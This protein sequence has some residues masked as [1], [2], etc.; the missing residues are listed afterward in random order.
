MKQ[1]HLHKIALLVAMLLI[2][3]ISWAD[4]LNVGDEFTENGI[5]YKVTNTSPLEAQVVSVDTSTEG[6]VTIVKRV[7]GSDGKYYSVTEIGGNA[8]RDCVQVTEVSIP[9]TVRSIGG[10]AFK[11]CKGLTS[12]LIPNSVTEIANEAFFNCY[13]LASVSLGNKVE[14]IG[15]LVFGNCGKITSL[16]LPSSLKTIGERGLAQMARLE[17][18]VIPKS[19]TEIGPQILFADY[20][21]TSI[22]VENGNPKYDSRDNCN[23]IICKDTKEIIQGCQEST[24]PEGVVSIGDYAFFYMSPINV[25][26]KFPS[27]LTNIGKGAFSHIGG[28]SGLTSLFIPKS[29]KTIGD[30]AFTNQST[31]EKIEV[32]EGNTEFDTRDG[33]NALIRTST[34][35]LIRAC[36]NSFIPNTVTTIGEGAFSSLGYYDESPEFTSINIP[37][38]VTKIGENAFWYC[39]QLVSVTLPNGLT[40]IGDYAFSGC[41]H[42]KSITIPASVEGIGIRAFESCYSLQTFFLLS[43]NPKEIRKYIV[44]DYAA[45]TL[46]VPAGTK[47]KYETTK[48]WS[49]FKNIT[50]Q[51]NY[52][53][54]KTKEGVVMRFVVVDNNSKECKVESID[55]ATSGE[56]TIPEIV[57]GYRVTAIQEE[58]FSNCKRLSSVVI[59]NSVTTIGSGAFSGCIG[60]K[61]VTLGESVISIGAGAF[62][63]CKGLNTFTINN[64]LRD[65]DKNA[66][67][68][69]TDL[70][71]VT[72]G[73]SVGNIGTGAFYNCLNLDKVISWIETPFAIDKGVFTYYDEESKVRV[74]TSATLYVPAGT[75]ALYEATDGWKEF[76]N[77][78]EMEPETPAYHDGEVFTAKI[79]EGIELR[80]TVI[81][82]AEKTCMLGLTKALDGELI[83]T[84]FAD[85]SAGSGTGMAELPNLAVTIPSKVNGYTVTEIG[86]RALSAS[87]LSSVT[88][89]S[90]VTTIHDMAFYSTKLRQLEIPS[91]VTSIGTNIAVSNQLKQ[92]TVKAGNPVYDSRK[93][94]NAIIETATNTLIL[95]CEETTI[96]E[97][98]ETIGKGALMG[99]ANYGMKEVYI[100]K[101]VTRIEDNPFFYGTQ[102]ESI[103]VASD[104]PVYNSRNNCNAII[105]TSTNELVVG[106][107]NTVIPKG[108]KRI[109][110]YA[111]SGLNDKLQQID[112]P[113]S[114]ESI[115]L[116]AF[117]GDALKE[118]IL[119]NGVRNIEASAFRQNEARKIRIPSTVTSI[120][121]MA[122]QI[123]SVNQYL[124]EVTSMMRKPFAINDQTFIESYYIDNLDRVT[125]YVPAGTKTKYEATEGW[126]LFKNIVEMEPEVPYEL[127]NNESVVVKNL[128]PD[129][130]G[131]LV[132]PEKV[133]IDGKE[134]PVTEIAA[135][136]FRDQEDIVE[137]TIPGTVTTIGAGAFAGCENLIAIYMLSP[138]PIDLEVAAARG[139]IRK[140]D[141]IVP[142]QFEGIDFEK[143]VLYVPYG[144]GETYSRAEGWK[145]F[146]HIVEM[147]DTGISNIG[148]GTSFAVYTTSGVL[149]K[150]NATTLKNLK[151]GVNIIRD[152]R[153]RSR[154]VVVK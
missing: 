10:S 12:I 107:K 149:V 153:G 142:S 92:I 49:E 93:N 151:K 28:G 13:N 78:V 139:V 113:A 45:I 91:S 150:K 100:P 87:K 14:S 34:N 133:E 9:S 48:G 108:V 84:A 123:S 39:R 127:I 101:S 61:S 55:A 83:T 143:C 16:E 99:I 67:S 37:N 56:L 22:K 126:K 76:K 29:V 129:E 130:N 32:E 140:A 51:N 124:T 60:L 4:A 11:G 141:G 82:E 86:E 21:L 71:E 128:E 118:I 38:S 69:C 112:I 85:G 144:S 59:G 50:D 106:C 114:V 27:S 146:K 72:I 94:C 77:I 119:P 66:F 73:K 24:I 36:H 5:K 6:G 131:K 23:A 74:F 95:G 70:K 105:K 44:D 18:I 75:K 57:N 52:I 120:G 109:G 33:C 154:K 41:D 64:T 138:T 46:Y 81:S 116:A 15:Y 2:P 134:Y 110:N 47:S 8:F 147:E 96:V 79:D 97:G 98:I 53:T 17:S 148:K 103:V 125:L 7:Q 102:I 54:G 115:G 117:R 43:E 111:F 137:V 40:T 26:L 152:S 65:I 58:A 89:P 20:S 132:I 42:L 30:G 31:M 104:N 25:S 88:I 19:V 122:F 63:Y 90:T 121:D 1:R 68:N 3:T 62:Y 145:L 35:E 80:F 136:A 135:D